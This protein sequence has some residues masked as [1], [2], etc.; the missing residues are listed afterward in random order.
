MP[1]RSEQPS[2]DPL[3]LTPARDGVTWA[4]STPTLSG[5]SFDFAVRCDDEQFGRYVEDLLAALATPGK[6]THCYSM[7]AAATG[8]IDLSLDGERIAQLATVSASVDWLLWDINRAVAGASGE[9]LLFHAGGVQMGDAGIVVPAPSGSG[10]STLVAGLVR[11]GLA[12][13]SDELVA[14]TMPG[15]QLLPY[16]KPLALKP[17]SFAVLNDLR[18]ATD[19]TPSHY[20]GD[21]WY[22]PV[23]HIANGMVGKPCDPRFVIVPHFATDAVTALVPLTRTEAFLAL[24]TNSVNLDDHG[25]GGAQMLGELVDRC[26]CYR[27]EMSD[28][29]Q[30]CHLVMA[31]VAEDGA[32]HV[33]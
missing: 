28:L 30:A 24:A 19:V 8:G 18:P 7:A 16:P 10:K 11:A 6:P 31:L 5:L 12:Y 17:G 29:T 25:A 27:L 14:L 23:Q 21:E 26:G 32:P 9:H 2:G 3:P 15:A 13:L 4:H 33:P 22:L 20:V 1:P